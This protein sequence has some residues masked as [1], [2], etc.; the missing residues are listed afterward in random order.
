MKIGILTICTGNYVIFFDEFYKS[1]QDLFLTDHEKVFFAFTDGSILDSHN[2][3]KIYQPRLGWPYDTMMRF[4]MFNSI[5]SELESMDYI[6]FFNVNMKFIEKIGDEVIPKEENDYL[7]GVNHPGY[8]NTEDEIDL[9]YERR[10]ESSMCVPYGLGRVYYQGC[11]NGG[12]SSEF[13]KMSEELEKMISSDLSI[14]ITPIWHDESALN[15]YYLPRNPLTLPPSY[16]Y[17]ESSNMGKGVDKKII[18]VDKN[19]FGGH[20]NLRNR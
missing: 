17:P 18:Q 1:C 5:R 4:N 19:R 11:F 20:W 14:G 2:I 15:W 9:P 8:F 10:F 6:F 7:M 12:R 16:A 13:L 3:N